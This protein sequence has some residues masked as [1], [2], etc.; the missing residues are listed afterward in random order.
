V[1][2]SELAQP[3]VYLPRSVTLERPRVYRRVGSAIAPYLYLAPVLAGFGI[4]VYR[5]L[6][7]TV[8][9]SFVEW[10]LVP[11]TPKVNVGW[12]NYRTLLSLPAFWQSLG[13][14]GI[15]IAGMILFGVLIPLGIGG[16]TQQIGR[17][18]Q[19]T[20][21]AI[22]FMPVLVSPLVAATIWSFLLAPNGGLINQTAGWVGVSPLNW[23]FDPTPA[24]ISIVLITGW[25]VLGVSVLIVAAGL[26]TINTEY[27]EAA[28]IDGASRWRVF[29]A[30]T[31]PLLSPSLLFL[32]VTAVLVAEAQVIFPLLVGLT[33]GGPSNA[34][35]DVYYLLYTYGFSSFN[36]GLAAAGAVIFFFLFAA[37]AI[38]CVALLDRISF[39]DD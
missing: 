8:Q 37:V 20:Y 26:A 27:Y 24:R 39:Y 36:V 38:A 32:F 31:L 30:V 1:T 21:R 12:A 34:T 23:L 5:P 19:R 35:T 13:T 9:Y 18:A 7:Q 33:Q 10:N 25:K 28:A 2:F 15:F 29:R 16:L 11:T 22:L 14:T 3:T 6:I 4:W 17:R